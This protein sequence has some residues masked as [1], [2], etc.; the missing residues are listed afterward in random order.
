MAVQGLLEELLVKVVTDET[1]G[2]TADEETV[3]GTGLEVVG[4]LLLGERAG[5]G[6]QVNERDGNGTVDVEDEGV[7]LGRGDVLDGEGVV[8]SGGGREVLLD[9]VDNE[10]D[11]EIGVTLALDLVTNTGDELVGLPHGVNELSRALARLE[12]TRELLGGTIEG[13]TEAV[14]DG[15]ETGTER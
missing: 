5:V 11:T 9:V 8:K 2:A 3:E 13:T 1:H 12:S 6:E 4:S 7:L 10:R 14:T 15:Q